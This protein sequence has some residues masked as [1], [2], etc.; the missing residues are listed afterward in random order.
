MVALLQLRDGPFVR[1]SALHL[2]WSLEARGHGMQAKDGKLTV[3]DG[4]RLTVE[5][6]AAIT[7]ERLHLLAVMGYCQEQP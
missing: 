1:E 6:R 7:R 3:T 4:S 5:D 2:A